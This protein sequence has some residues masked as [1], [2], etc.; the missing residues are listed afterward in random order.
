[1]GKEYWLL[2]RWTCGFYY[3]KCAGSHEQGLLVF[4][5]IWFNFFGG[6]ISTRKLRHANGVAGYTCKLSALL[7]TA[8]CGYVL[9]H[10]PASLS[11]SQNCSLSAVFKTQ[12][13]LESSP[14][15]P[16]FT[17]HKPVTN[18]ALWY[19]PLHLQTQHR[20]MRVDK[21]GESLLSQACF[22]STPIMHHH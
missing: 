1:M 10:S 21:S 8:V 16:S 12:L 4:I 17:T 7:I 22:P 13:L 6:G 9:S 15:N 19:P 11:L 14:G 18:T 20:D 3:G 2:G 5:L